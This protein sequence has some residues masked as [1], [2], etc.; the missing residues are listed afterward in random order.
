MHVFGWRDRHGRQATP[1]QRGD[2]LGAVWLR[3]ECGCNPT[4]AAHDCPHA[5][6]FRV[7][8]CA[9]NGWQKTEYG[10]ESCF[11]P[12]IP[13]EKRSDQSLAGAR[14]EIPSPRFLAPGFRGLP[15]DRLHQRR[16]I[17]RHGHRLAATGL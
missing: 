1:T 10:I 6:P 3:A 14:V 4:V 2:R 12:P 17:G 15:G 13:N 7:Y 11:C 5:A 16:R 9:G 8:N